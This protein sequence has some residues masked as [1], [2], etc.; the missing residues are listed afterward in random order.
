MMATWINGGASRVAGLMACT[1]TMMRATQDRLDH[2]PELLDDL[3]NCTDVSCTTMMSA[4]IQFEVANIQA[5][6][7]QIQLVG[8]QA[9]AFKD[10]EIRQM[11]QKLRADA[12]NDAAGRGG[13]WEDTP[14]AYDPRA[15]MFVQSNGTG[16]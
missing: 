15:P 7:H 12:E 4:R 5:Q 13:S 10:V 16:G 1:D 2:L 6:Q 3:K 8:Q 14:N 9:E 11:M